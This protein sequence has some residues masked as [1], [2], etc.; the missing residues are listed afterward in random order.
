MLRL[1]HRKLQSQINADTEW[2]ARVEARL[3]IIERDDTVPATGIEIKQVPTVRVAELS[4]R[5][6]ISLRSPSPR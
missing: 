5:P 1:R 2:L 6:R 3:Q 4:A